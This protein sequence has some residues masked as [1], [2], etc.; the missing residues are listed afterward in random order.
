MYNNQG[1]GQGNQR[2][3]QL[4]FGGLGLYAKGIAAGIGLAS[5]SI[6]AHKEKKKKTTMLATGETHQHQSQPPYHEQARSVEPP[7]YFHGAEQSFIPELEGEGSHSSQKESSGER[8]RAQGN[9]DEEQWDLDDAQDDFL[10]WEPVY[11][12]KRPF[13]RDPK[14]IVQYFIDDYPLPQEI[15]SPGRLTLPVVLPQR[16]PKDRTRGFI[17][18]YAPDLMNAGIDQDMFLDFLETFN[19]ATQASPW[20]N[21]INMA[22]IA[23]LPLHLAPGIEPEKVESSPSAFC[24]SEIVLI[25]CRNRHHTVMDQMNEQFFQPRGLHAMILTWR[26]EIDA[27]EVGVNFNETFL[28]TTA[29][30]E[31]IAKVVRNL[32]PSTGTTNGVP[33]TET[34]PLVFPALDKLADDQT[35][36]GRTKK[37]KIKG[38]M[39]FASEYFDRRAQ[40]KHAL[41]NPD[42]QLAVG[43]KPTFTSRYSNPSN[44]TNSGDLLALVTAG[45][46]SMPARGGFGGV[47]GGARLDGRAIMRSCSPLNDR[48]AMSYGGP[49]GRMGMMGGSMGQQQLVDRPSPS[50]MGYNQQYASQ[51]TMNQM[52]NRKTANDL[53]M[54]GP[55]IGFGGVNLIVN[56]VMR[57]LRHHVLYLLIINLPTEEE[58]ANAAPFMEQTY[59]ELQSA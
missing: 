32:K 25:R 26:P 57:V 29:P 3:Q 12:N 30:P 8:G 21:A 23:L 42:S 1:F 17:R 2:G 55:Q 40:A 20:M 49:R 59:S 6:H 10:Q 47:G 34:A 45:K 16:R 24:T 56:G 41:E 54:G 11:P 31:G 44:S 46:L 13:A 48:L 51:T 9:G 53:G 28:K 52:D 27:T 58:M 38:M 36:A 7:A 37:E 14:K 35:G 15:Q 4:G 19:T 39:N 43:P 5:E 18:A 50:E 22:G 33:F